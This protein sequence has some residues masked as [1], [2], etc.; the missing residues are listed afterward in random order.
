MDGLN[1]VFVFVGG[2]E[3]LGFKVALSG[4]GTWRA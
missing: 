3:K 1:Y 2:E 4:G